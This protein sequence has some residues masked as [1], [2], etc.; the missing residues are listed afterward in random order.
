MYDE[1]NIFAKILR[2]EIPCNKVYED[3]SVLAFNDISPAAPTH[4]LVIPKKHVANVK[5]CKDA[6][7]LGSL[8]KAA[9][10]VAE[11]E[12]LE[13]GFRLVVNTGDHGGQTVFHVHIHILGGRPLDW[14]PG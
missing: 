1:N 13:E 12:K 4:I 3:E 8:F 11:E 10:R 2:K 6:G 14:P 7:E 5:E 9:T